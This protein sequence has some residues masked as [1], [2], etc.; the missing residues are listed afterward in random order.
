MRSTAIATL[1]GL[2]L[3]GSVPLPATASLPPAPSPL[4]LRLDYAAYVDGFRAMVIG[5]DLR[6]TDDGYAVALQDH[7]VGMVG[8]LIDNHVSSRAD[9]RFDVDGVVPSSYRSAGHSRG[10]DRQTAITW[11]GAQPVVRVLSPV[12][13]NRDKVPAAETTG[14]VDALS[15]VAL[16]FRHLARVGRCDASLHVFDGARL[17]AVQA[18]T[19]GTTVLPD[20]DRSPFAGAAATCQFRITER[21]G[22]IHSDSFARQHD[23]QGGTVWLRPVVPNGPPLPVRAEFSTMEHGEV[24]L[25][26]TAATAGPATTAPATAAQSSP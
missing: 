20:S 2:A 3:A 26:L 14:A 25:F 6:L 13:P 16:L 22:F 12:E 17:S 19:A 24:R 1:L 4:S 11:D 15:G 7:T 9:G 18:W 23:P 21:A 5:V 10:A 8:A